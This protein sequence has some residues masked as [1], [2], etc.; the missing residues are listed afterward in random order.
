MEMIVTSRS[1]EKFRIGLVFFESQK[2]KNVNKVYLKCLDQTSQL[3]DTHCHHSYIKYIFS[4]TKPFTPRNSD[5]KKSGETFLRRGVQ[6]VKV[7]EQ[8]K[9]STIRIIK[10]SYILK[11]PYFVIVFKHPTH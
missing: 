11:L 6:L 7:H 3:Y 1:P 9:S 4:H 8:Q 2:Y 10:Y 5:E